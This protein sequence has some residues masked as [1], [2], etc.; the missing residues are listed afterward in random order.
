MACE[1]GSERAIE[2]RTERGNPCT[3]VVEEDGLKRRVLY[4]HGAR[5]TSLVLEPKVVKWM[6]AQLDCERSA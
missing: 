1:P 4:F 3:I 6:A 2:G 5:E